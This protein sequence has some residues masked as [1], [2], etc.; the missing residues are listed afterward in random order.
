[1]RIQQRTPTFFNIAWRISVSF[2]IVLS[3]HWFVDIRLSLLYIP[4]GERGFRVG[5]ANQAESNKILPRDTS[6]VRRANYFKDPLTFFLQKIINVIA[7]KTSKVSPLALL[8]PFKPPKRPV[9]LTFRQV[10]FYC[11]LYTA[12]VTHFV[13]FGCLLPV[14]CPALQHLLW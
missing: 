10:A 14:W 1:M 11:P 13:L 5:L 12:T 4:S 3:V 9:G 6:K 8:K 7:Y 2:D